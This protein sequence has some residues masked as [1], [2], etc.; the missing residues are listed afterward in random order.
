MIALHRPPLVQT[1]LMRCGCNLCVAPPQ[2]FPEE[3]KARTA[4]KAATRSARNQKGAARAA[5]E[6]AAQQLHHTHSTAVTCNGCG[7]QF[8]GRKG[9]LAQHLRVC[10]EQVPRRHA[11]PCCMCKQPGHLTPKAA[12]C[13][14][15]A[16]AEWRQLSSGQQKQKI[17]EAKLDWIAT[18]KA[19]PAVTLTLE[20]S[21][22]ELAEAAAPIG[23]AKAVELGTTGIDVVP[24]TYVP[25]NAATPEFGV[26]FSETLQRCVVASVVDKTPTHKKGMVRPDWAVLRVGDEDAT[27]WDAATCARKIHNKAQA[28]TGAAESKEASSAGVVLVLQRSGPKHIWPQGWAV[29]PPRRNNPPLTNEQ[30]EWLLRR[31]GNAKKLSHTPAPSALKRDSDAFFKAKGR[32]GLRMPKKRIGAWVKNYVSANK[33]DKLAQAVVAVRAIIEADPTGAGLDARVARGAHPRTA[34]AHDAPPGRVSENNTAAEEG[35]EPVTTDS[36]EDNSDSGDATPIPP[37]PNGFRHFDGSVVGIDLAGDKRRIQYR[38]GEPDG[39]LNGTVERHEG[40]RAFTCDFNDDDA[41]RIEV[42]CS[43]Q[44]T[45]APCSIRAVRPAPWISPPLQQPGARVLSVVSSLPCIAGPGIAVATCA[46]G[47]SLFPS[48][49]GTTKRWVLLQSLCS[50]PKQ[51]K[52]VAVIPEGWQVEQCPTIFDKQYFASR[53]DPQQYMFLYNSLAP[54][55]WQQV[56]LQRAKGSRGKQMEI[57]AKLKFNGQG[58]PF[59]K[60]PR[61]P[62]VEGKPNTASV[63]AIEITQEKYGTRG[64]FV[65]LRR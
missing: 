14:A 17:K 50:D 1:Q 33:R 18:Q 29:K 37:P 51:T 58:W 24:V 5:I 35:D 56:T 63:R 44:A 55:D 11:M 15:E 26:K 30:T 45:A 65:A 46:Q 3:R 43:L 2:S 41:S 28:T 49:H 7:R 39:W 10:T 52:A 25:R 4:K 27:A 23:K 34:R 31:V 16:K 36:D 8:S 48:E 53:T 19:E 13:T 47:L 64:R 38:F 20:P 57:A 9:A 32:P 60:I 54:Y 62:Y 40:G 61:D 22:E 12:S 21:M 6:A 59:F 42:R